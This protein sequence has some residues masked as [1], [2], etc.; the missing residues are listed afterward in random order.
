M[1]FPYPNPLIVHTAHPSLPKT[2]VGVNTHQLPE[3]PAEGPRVTGPWIALEGRSLMAVHLAD[4]TPW[5]HGPRRA[6]EGPGKSSG[7]DV[8]QCETREMLEH[9]TQQ[10]SPSVYLLMHF[11]FSDQTGR[12]TLQEG[13]GK[14][15]LPASQGRW[16]Q[17]MRQ[18]C[19]GGCERGW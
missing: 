4:L 8:Q 10:E 13:R 2:Q 12:E 5:S 15:V 16:R 11:C 1:L 7:D 17:G 14:V 3:R 9:Q 19:R 18:S 6:I